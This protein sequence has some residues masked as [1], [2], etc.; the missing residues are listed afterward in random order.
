MKKFLLYNKT[1]Y[2]VAPRG[3]E[4]IDYLETPAVLPPWISE[5]DLQVYA[6]KFEESGFTGALNYF[7]TIEM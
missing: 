4:I 6:Q 7:R 1:D 3:M 2:L 5:E